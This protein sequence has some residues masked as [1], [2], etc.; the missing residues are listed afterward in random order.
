MVMILSFIERFLYK[1]SDYLIS[2]LKNFDIYLKSLSIS[3]PYKF[4]PQSFYGYN[5]SSLKIEVPEKL[6][7]YKKIGIYA[8]SVGSFYKI[9][10][11]LTFFPKNLKNHIA[12]III[13]DGDRFNQI[14]LLKE[15]LKLDNFFHI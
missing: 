14:K 12:I 11:L 9:E 6:K 15:Q 2:P 4:I 13:G 5:D 8:G 10:N 3:N 1:K 7:S